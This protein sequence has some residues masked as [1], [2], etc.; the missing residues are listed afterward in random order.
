MKSKKIKIFIYI[1]YILSNVIKIILLL[2]IIYLLENL[3]LI[4]YTCSLQNLVEK[5]KN[6]L[7]VHKKGNL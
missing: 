6:N 4:K 7:K 3:I 2:Y 5:I 1:L